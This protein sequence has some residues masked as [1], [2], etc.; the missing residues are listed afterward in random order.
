[1]DGNK[2]VAHEDFNGHTGETANLTF[3]KVPAN[4]DVDGKLPSSSYTFTADDNQVI[5]INLKHQ[6][7]NTQDSKTVKRTINVTTPD[8]KTTTLTVQKANLSRTNVRDKVTGEITNGDWSKDHFAE[9][10]DIPAVAG[11]TPSQT[12]VEAQDVD[13]T[14]PDSTVTITY[15]ANAQTVR[16]RYM[17]GNKEVAHEDFNGHTD[18]TTN[19]KFDKV[20]ANYDVDGKLPS[21]KY[22]FTADSNQ[23][24]TIK[25]KHQME[26]LPESKQVTRTIN[27]ITPDGKT[28]TTVQKVD[29]SRTNVRDKVTGNITDGAWSKSHF[30]EFT[31]IP[32]IPGYTPSQAKVETQDVDSTTPDSTVTITYTANKQTVRV[33]YMD[34][35]KEVIHED[36]NG[37]TGETTNLTFDKVPANYDV[38][39]SLPSTSYT[40]TADSNQVIT[41]NLKHQ[42]ENLPDSKTVTRTINVITPDGKTKTTV[43]K[44]DLSRT[45]VRDKVTGEITDG[46]WNTGRFD[47]FDDIPAIAGY[48]PSQTKVAAQDVDSTTPD[49]TVTITYRANEQTGKISYIDQKTN[50]EIKSN[51][52]TGVT[53]GD[54]AIKLDVPAG[55][56]L[57]SG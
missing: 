45:N 39:G 21:S 16:V 28:K 38:I 22:Q 55:Y 14:T 17:D 23:V 41:I 42:M 53:D 50:E 54:V 1:M 7:E 5:T 37:H 8:G 40:F 12:K 13:G 26:N 32:V 29:L 11:Y 18:E 47:E 57:V 20:P 24:I 33:R 52:L 3:N 15:T 43:Q 56:H 9:F 34:G 10:D 4:Y 46:T 44:V 48:T 51:P 6:T 19:L 49:S 25:L 30:D 35:D 2:E 31:D 27:V 36:F